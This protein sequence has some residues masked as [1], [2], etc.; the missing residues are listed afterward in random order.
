MQ[1]DL[2][3]EVGLL[4]SSAGEAFGHA[5]VV[6]DLSQQDIA[7]LSGMQQASVSRFESGCNN[8]TLRTMA[9]MAHALGKRVE[10]KL[11]DK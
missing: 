7:E 3:D 5:R 10:I 4:L 9:R 1:K 11:V 6:A 2:D 8:V